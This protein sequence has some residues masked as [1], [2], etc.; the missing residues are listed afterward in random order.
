MTLTWMLALASHFKS[1]T[2]KFLCLYVFSS[3]EPKAPG[4]LIV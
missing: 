1:L 3:P 2:S 4:E